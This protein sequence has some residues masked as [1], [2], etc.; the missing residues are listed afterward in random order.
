EPVKRRPSVAVPSLAT[1]PT[2]ISIGLTKI[3]Q[4]CRED[5][6]MKRFIVRLLCTLVVVPALAATSQAVS[7]TWTDLTNNDQWSNNG[8]WSTTHEPTLSD[9]VIFPTPIPHPVNGFGQVSANLHELAQSLTFNAIY[10]IS[11]A[12]AGTDLQLATGN[13]TCNQASGVDD[14]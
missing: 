5:F 14:I 3:P 11:P 10:Q 13:I 4:S 12:V 1:S 2:A 7:T 6:P 9:D 8:N